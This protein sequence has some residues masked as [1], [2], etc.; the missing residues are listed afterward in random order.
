[1]VA[2]RHSERLHHFR[3]ELSSVTLP[4]IYLANYPIGLINKISDTLSTKE[5]LFQENSALKAELFLMKANLQKQF[6]L[7][8]VNQQLRALLESGSNIEEKVS[9]ARLLA[10]SVEP[11]IHQVILNKGRKQQVF[12]GQAVLDATG[13]MGQVIEV[14]EE[15]SR[16]MLLTD[17]R[18]AIPVQNK[19][20][21][22]RAIAVGFGASNRIKLREMTETTDIKEGDEIITSGLGGYYPFGYPVGVVVSIYRN[23]GEGFMEALVAPAA[24][25]DRSRLVLLVYSSSKDKVT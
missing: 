15:T 13:V 3:I 7:E 20:N 12:A 23:N 9:S 11:F 10:V 25:L 2:D 16:V 21:G 1:M 4:L 19:R 24:H 18:S 14:G 6:A 22:V 8:S 5:Q 17:S